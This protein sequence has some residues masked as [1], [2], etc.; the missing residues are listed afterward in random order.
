MAGF[1][2]VMSRPLNV[3]L[4]RVGGRKEVSR[5]KHVVLPAPLGPIRA[6]MLPVSTDRSTA[7]TATKP[8]NSRVRPTVSRMVS[9]TPGRL[10][11][12]Q[13]VPVSGAFCI[14]RAAVQGHVSRMIRER[15]RSSFLA[16]HSG[17]LPKIGPGGASKI[18]ELYSRMGRSTPAAG[19]AMRPWGAQARSENE[20]QVHSGGPHKHRED[21]AVHNPS[22]QCVLVVAHSRAAAPCLTGGLHRR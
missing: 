9:V 22:H 7:S 1:I 8:L 10:P 3:I 14:C 11:I 4:P 13:L 21:D 15:L 5:L 18:A 2:P 12:L 17:R 19:E 6:W 16:A 20:G